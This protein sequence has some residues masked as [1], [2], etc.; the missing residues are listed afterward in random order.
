MTWEPMPDVSRETLDHLG[1]FERL[2]KKWT[3]KINLVS[4]ST[5]STIR[6]RHTLDSVQVFDHAPK[7]AQ[8]WV[9]LGSGG[10][11]PG[12]VCAILA[13]GRGM[14]T[15]FHLVESDTRKATFLRTAIRELSLNAQ[16]HAKRIEALRNLPADVLS[17]RALADLPTLL[18]LSEPYRKPQTVSLFPK[19]QSWKSEVETA[20]NQWSFDLETCTSRTNPAASILKI[21]GVARV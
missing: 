6:G 20:R 13:K 15:D 7:S 9:D 3:Q 8:V 18:E 11:Y 21:T 12:I 19:G 5:V 17:A 2:V 4:S 10:G 1:A 14:R 16:V